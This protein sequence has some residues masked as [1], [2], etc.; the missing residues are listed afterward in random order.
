VR[1]EI[2]VRIAR[3]YRELGEDQKAASY[4]E[5]AIREAPTGAAAD[6]A[7]ALQQEWGR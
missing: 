4:L 6:Q 7:R 5:R 1:G 3:L 2:C